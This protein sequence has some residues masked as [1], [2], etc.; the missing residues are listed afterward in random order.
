LTDHTQ[1]PDPAK[2]TIV[3]ELRELTAV[4]TGS[5]SGIGRAI[6]LELAGAG[7][8]IL[9]HGRSRRDA[10]EEVQREIEM[11]GRAAGVCMGD[12]RDH[13]QLAPFVE[14]CWQWRGR[15]DV[16]I[17]NAGADVLTGSAANLSFEEK[18]HELW[19]VDV[20]GTIRLSRLVGQRMKQRGQGVILNMGWDQAEQGMAG[21]SGQL[22]S[23]IKGAVMAFTR[24]LAQSL[25]PQVRV[26]CLAPGWIKT[27]WGQQASDAWQQ[28]A[29]Q[30]SLLGRWGTPADIAR[31]ARFLASPAAA[32]I[33]GQVIAIN[34]GFRYG[35]PG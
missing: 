1:Q 18:L 20:L 28:R 6:A 26:N 15:V 7:A 22:F 34:G 23:S 12:L 5:T 13:A 33:N 32:F 16:W 27:S 11:L 9:I 3:H 24:S 35:G 10:A 4:V 31:A 8:D 30:E 25:A 17:N 14:Q 21:D 19:Q 2:R 29:C